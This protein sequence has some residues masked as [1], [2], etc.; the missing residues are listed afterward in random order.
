MIPEMLHPV[1]AG[2]STRPA[3]L[4]LALTAAAVLFAAT[5]TEAQAQFDSGGYTSADTPEARAHQSQEQTQR[6]Q[7][8]GLIPSATSLGPVPELQVFAAVSLAETYTSNASG[9]VGSS[10][11]DFYTRPGIHLGFNEQTRH[12]TASANYS[13]TGQY[14]AREHDFNQ[15]VH[16]LNAMANAELI[17]QTLFMD[18]QAFAQPASLTR[19]GALTAN[20]GTPTNNNYRD[21]YGYAVRPTLM[22]QF[23]NAVETDLWFSQSGVFFVTPNSANTVPLPGFF[24]PPTN[25]NTSQVGAR[26][27]SLDRFVRLKWSINGSASDTYQTAHNSQKVRSATANAS[28]AVTN[29]IA[30]IATGGYQTY[31]SSY[32]LNKDL[33]G[34]T[35]LG[36]LQFTPSPDFYLFVQAGTQSNFP[37]YIG[38]LL[39]KVTPRTTISANAT[40]QVQTPQQQLLGNL[41]NPAGLPSPGTGLPGDTSAPPPSTPATPGINTPSGFL[42][43]GL[44][45][46][47]SVYRYRQFN[48]DAHRTSER[49]S[50]GITAYATLRDRLNDLPFNLLNTHEKT[51]G[52]SADLRHSLRR[53]LIGGL[54]IT[55]SRA[56]EFNGN[57]RILE[58]DASLNY[59]ASETL[60]FNFLASVLNSQ[61]NNLIG[62]A[63]GDRTDVRITVG[64]TKSF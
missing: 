18:A 28:Y 35:L 42:G 23:G 55:A 62:F 9:T 59:I 15:L 64:V 36:G 37:T 5:V 39:W 31:H 24:R 63:N 17:E 47:N 58:G 60:S 34:P 54:R 8:Q 25:S 19:A 1:G 13:L 10:Q 12:L 16:R 6:A 3:T 29:S 51:Y 61:S 43:D 7:Q 33:D 48:F 21:T 30:L 45:I 52:I 40:D 50:Y 56:N 14:Y 44:S 4:K 41:Q 26:I 32:L 22:H 57:D 53:D 38:R 27:S 20:D 46:D 11:D 49:T 2:R